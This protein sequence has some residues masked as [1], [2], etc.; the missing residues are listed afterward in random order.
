MNSLSCSAL[1]E[2]L[3]S[4]AEK[5]FFFFVGV[6]VGLNNQLSQIM[7]AMDDVLKVMYP[8]KLTGI[9]SAKNPPQGYE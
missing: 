7:V 9:K 6:G 8:L 2:T 5:W 4:T 1:W 3:A